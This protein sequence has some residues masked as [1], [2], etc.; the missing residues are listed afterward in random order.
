MPQPLPVPSIDSVVQPN[1]AKPV[2]KSLVGVA[3]AQSLHAPCSH[4]S[5]HAS[6]LGQSWHAFKPLGSR[7]LAQ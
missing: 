2:E 5:A 4:H 3:V 6:P 7:L 1:V